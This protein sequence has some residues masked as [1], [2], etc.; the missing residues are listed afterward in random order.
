MNLK[1]STWRQYTYEKRTPEPDGFLSTTRG[2]YWYETTIEKWNTERKQLK[3]RYREDGTRMRVHRAAY[4]FAAE[5]IE[6]GKWR[7]YPEHGIVAT[8]SICVTNGYLATRLI[9]PNRE[10]LQVVHHRIIWEWQ[11]G[12][13]VP[14]DDKLVVDH[15]NRIRWDNR[16]DNLRSIT[17]A[18]NML[19]RLD[20]Q[21]RVDEWMQLDSA[22][23]LL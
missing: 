16:L 6:H 19:N 22:D 7:V 23:D 1:R 9:T 14:L 21:Y 17:Q 12:S 10:Q 20:S 15:K 3:D 13:Y 8:S 18:E 11:T 5:L 2:P 4:D